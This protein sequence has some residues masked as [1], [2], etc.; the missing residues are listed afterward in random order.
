MCDSYSIP[1]AL[2]TSIPQANNRTWEEAVEHSQE[3]VN[4][5]YDGT[6]YCAPA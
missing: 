3:G 6:A 4:E 2:N 1:D 5:Y